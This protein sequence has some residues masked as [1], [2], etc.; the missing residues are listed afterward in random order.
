MPSGPLAS[1]PLSGREV[2]VLAVLA[3]GLTDSQIGERLYISRNTVK[4]HLHRC[5][6]KLGA[7]NRTDAVRIARERGLIG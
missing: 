7:Q 5:Y 3:E 4:N 6:V 2:E 1:R